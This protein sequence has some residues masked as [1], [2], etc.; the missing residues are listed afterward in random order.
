[1]YYGIDL[2][3]D[4][5]LSFFRTSATGRNARILVSPIE[6]SRA[7]PRSQG[8]KF[9]AAVPVAVY[10]SG[11]L[12][13]F[14]RTRTH[15]SGAERGGSLIGLCVSMSVG[16]WLILIVLYENQ[17][18][19]KTL[20]HFWK[21]VETVE[22][23]GEILPFLSNDLASSG[24][25]GPRTRDLSFPVYQHF[26]TAQHPWF[27]RKSAVFGCKNAS[28]CAAYLPAR[29][30]SRLKPN[31]EILIIYGIPKNVQHLTQAMLS[32][33]EPIKLKRA[34]SIPEKSLVLISDG[35]SSD[36]FIASTVQ[37]QTIFHEQ[38][39]Y[40]NVR[41]FLSKAYPKGSEMMELQSVAYYLG[42]PLRSQLQTQS[43]SLYRD[44][45]AQKAEEISEGIKTISFSY[46][47]AESFKPLRFAKAGTFSNKDWLWVKGLRIQIDFHHN[48]SWRYDFA[49]RNGPC[50][51]YYGSYD[52]PY[53]PGV[54][55]FS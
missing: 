51:Y 35:L 7:T 47:L 17:L 40:T 18:L 8:A 16:L 36:L 42:V 19:Y 3:Y 9:Q 52:K 28:D 2:E 12:G 48:P 24:Y 14:I 50:A 13:C 44:D 4:Q 31:S 38:T 10:H 49:L 54:D 34:T 55:A 37:G 15:Y 43:F 45:L 20:S 27:G 30:L 53:Y 46:A 39:P 26:N 5:C 11:A 1:M 22:K 33:S 21:W 29:A 32:A 41:G 6:R 23:V 25:R